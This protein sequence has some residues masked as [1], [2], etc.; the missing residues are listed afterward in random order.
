MNHNIFENKI[1]P[2]ILYIGTIVAAVMAIAYFICVFVLIEGFKVDKI[3]NTS[4]FSIVT[5]LIGFFIM[6]MLKIQGQSFAKNLPENQEIIKKYYSTKTK[7]KKPR[8][9]KYYWIVS[10]ITDA[11]TK[12]LT[13]AITSVG[14]VYIMIEGSGDYK[15][16]LLAF[17]NILMFAGFG[18]ISLV[19]AYDFYNTSYIPYM[20]ERLSEVEKNETTIT[21]GETT[22]TIQTQTN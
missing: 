6:Q 10:T 16:L 19:K 22:C 2:L 18:L 14:I 1:K 21:E 12:C 4:L 8:S 9:M 11:L 7:D 20:K 13:L 15:L 5:A 3:L 17:V